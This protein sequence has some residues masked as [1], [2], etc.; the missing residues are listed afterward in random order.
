M[1]QSL[2]VFFACAFGAFIGGFTSL[3]II[4]HF[5]LGGIIFGGLVGYFSFEFEKVIHAIPVAYTHATTWR[6]DWGWWLA[7][8]KISWYT[9]RIAT[10]IGV[11]VLLFL[12]ILYLGGATLTYPMTEM[13]Q[14]GIVS[15]IAAGYV[16]GYAILADEDEEAIPHMIKNPSKLANPFKVYLW[17]IPRGIL[18]G[19]RWMVLCLPICIF[20]VWV[21]IKGISKLSW[22]LF[23]LIHSEIRLLCGLDATIGAMIGYYCG[24]ALI[25]AVAGGIL[26]VLNFELLSIRFF[27][28]VPQTQSFFRN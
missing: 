10:T 23:R 12:K 16:F 13:V 22:H 18:L 19:L 2:K 11:G 15:I 21:G 4:P 28:F 6:P 17:I 27:K 8:I 5:Y 26:G 9:M 3:Q 14:I 1:P 7:Y 24:N 25:G 20:G